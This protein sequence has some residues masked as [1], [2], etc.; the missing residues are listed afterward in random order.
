MKVAPDP[1]MSE[2]VRQRLELLLAELQPRHAIED[3]PWGVPSGTGGDPPGQGEFGVPATRDDPSGTGEAAGSAS[4]PPR[5]GR[6][7][8]RVALET[9]GVVARAAERVA[10][11]TREHLAAVV[12]LLLV[13][14]GWT[15]YTMLQARSTPVAVATAPSVADAPSVAVSPTPSATPPAK[16]LVHVIGAVRSP[17]VVELAEG[18]RVTDAIAA[19]GGL[20]RTADTGQLN[21]AAVVADGSQVVVG[22]RSKPGG[23]IRGAGGETG[24]GDGGTAKVSLNTATLE[25]LDTLPGVGPV[26]AQRILDW[27]K[28]HG[29]FAAVTEL[30]EVEGIGPKTYADLAPN[31]RV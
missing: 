6:P 17:G 11:F 3:D 1:V 22:T 5:A 15:V 10:G 16:V 26:T 19:A 12:V 13:G 18:S 27:R 29:R 25:Q 8:Q 20:T 2:V 21:L 30:Q 24:G 31:V 14:C 28:E 7:G 4:P 23:E 9:G